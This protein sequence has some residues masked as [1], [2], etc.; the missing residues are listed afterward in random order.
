[1]MSIVTVSLFNWFSSF[2]CQFYSHS[3]HSCKLQNNSFLRRVLHIYSFRFKVSSRRQ[4][5][6]VWVDTR[7]SIDRRFRPFPRQGLALPSK[8][9]KCMCV[10]VRSWVYI[11]VCGRTSAFDK[12]FS[13]Q[14]MWR[15]HTR[16]I[17]NAL[18]LNAHANLCYNGNLWRGN[19]VTSILSRRSNNMRRFDINSQV[20]TLWTTSRSFT[21]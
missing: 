12:G 4:S 9:I 17:T 8:L 7:Y 3:N 13:G 6:Y 2:V 10:Y 21:C 20:V 19:N 1:M 15:N 14:V 11:C 18:W 16:S 5:S